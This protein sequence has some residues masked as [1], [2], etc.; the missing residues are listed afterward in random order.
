MFYLDVKIL[1]KIVIFFL[2]LH[3]YLFKIVTKWPDYFSG[4]GTVAIL[5]N[6][7]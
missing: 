5:D 2:I 7:I 4:V 6:T 1:N 3:I